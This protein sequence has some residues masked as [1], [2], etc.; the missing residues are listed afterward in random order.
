MIAK[1]TFDI[2]GFRAYVRN[3]IGH[4]SQRAFAKAHGMTP[5]HLNRMLKSPCPPVP[6]TKTCRK[7][8]GVDNAV[9]EDL[10]KLAAPNVTLMAMPESTEPA[11]GE[12]IT[13][14]DYQQLAAR[15]INPE[16]SNGQIKAHALWGLAA[17]VGELQGLY[18]KAYQGH[19]LDSEHAKKEVG[20]ILWM[21]A[22]YCTAQGWDLGEIMQLN[23]DKLRTRYPEGFDPEHSL[24]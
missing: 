5:E 2:D 23:I 14:H 11:A 15:T 3:L 10:L 6:S 18:Q 24:H 1:A 21:V 7:L 16:L 9:Y 13:A 19:K 22:E 8:A 20:D 17:E 4:Q 12:P